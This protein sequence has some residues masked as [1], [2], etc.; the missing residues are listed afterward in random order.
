[1]TFLLLTSNHRWWLITARKRADTAT[2]GAWPKFSCGS[3]CS[4]T[5][6]IVHMCPHWQLFPSWYTT[7]ACVRPR[8]RDW[9]SMFFSTK[10]TSMSLLVGCLQVSACFWKNRQNKVLQICSPSAKSKSSVTLYTRHWKK[11]IFPMLHKLLCELVINLHL[12]RLF[13]IK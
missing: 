1:M 8:F 6:V 7:Y 9:Y 3:E 2:K 5:H 13:Q 12:S 10:E 11:K 4:H